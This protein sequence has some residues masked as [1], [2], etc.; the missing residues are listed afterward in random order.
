MTNENYTFMLKQK[1]DLE[2]NRRIILGTR[3]FFDDRKVVTA[4]A[5]IDEIQDL[6]ANI[7]PEEDDTALLSALQITA[8][9]FNLKFKELADLSEE[10]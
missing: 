7:N 6:I 2:I 10:I 1:E 8:K 4:L 5:L 9:A 3:E